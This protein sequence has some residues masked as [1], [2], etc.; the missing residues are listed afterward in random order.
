MIR[1]LRI[2]TRLA[3]IFSV[4]IALLIA[5]GAFELDRLGTLH[6]HLERVVNE[7][8]GVIAQ[9]DGAIERHTDNARLMMQ[10][11]LLAE[12]DQQD[13]LRQVEGEMKVNSAAI[14][15][16]LDTLKGMADAPRE[17]ALYAELA[18]HREPYLASRD[19]AK[20]LL[21]EGKRSEAI[22]L[23]HNETMPLLSSY[24]QAWTDFASYER[25][26]MNDAV[27]DA[28]STY[29]H[30]RY[31]LFTLVFAAILV[32]MLLS[33][34]VTRS[35]ARPLELIVRHVE[36]LAEGDLR[37]SVQ[38]SGND[39]MT[40]LQRAMAQMTENLSGMLGEVT[41]GS[42]TLSAAAAQVA[43]TSQG[44]SQGTSEQASSVEETSASLEEISASITQNATSGKEADRL[45]QQGAKDAEGV[46][47]AVQQAVQAMR[48]IADRVGIIEEIAYRT[49]LLSLNAAIEAARAGE[50]GRGF[51]VVAAEVRKLAERSER[52]ATEIRTVARDSV[53]IAE[54]SEEQLLT[55]VPAI[56]KTSTLLQDVAAASQDQASGVEEITGAMSRVDQVTQRNASAAEEL[57]ATS[58]ELSQQA[59]SL[60]QIVGRFQ[61]A[62]PAPHLGGPA[63]AQRLFEPAEHP[64]PLVAS[65]GAKPVAS[66]EGD[67]RPFRSVE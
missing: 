44:L 40:R 37:S 48:T 7:H 38:I 43:S 31:L 61:L 29:Q 17:Q 1:N 33:V 21:K 5:L 23:L 34:L 20:A 11:L 53:K 27:A 62:H 28:T 8:Y 6:D 26:E 49:N 54:R 9:V 25:A 59:D 64:R 10:G 13:A 15:Q 24:R 19:H 47:R 4:L 65:A 12:V 36:R 50:Q 14:T 46:A 16:A 58:E 60:R 42:V 3:V 66:E 2:G 32:A 45:A 41:A 67:F 22:L 63:R 35:I 52:A 55:L 56:Q 51:S 39:E 18:P 57:A 30:A